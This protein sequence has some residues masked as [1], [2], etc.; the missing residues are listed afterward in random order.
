MIKYNQMK[1]GGGGGGI[2]IVVNFKKG[3]VRT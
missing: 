1:K 3:K 2:I